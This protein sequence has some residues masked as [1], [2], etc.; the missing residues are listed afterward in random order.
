MSLGTNNTYKTDRYVHM[1][2]GAAGGKLPVT[3]I[4]KTRAG[5]AQKFLESI[6]HF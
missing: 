3:A 4:G 2:P 6:F 1:L 5:D